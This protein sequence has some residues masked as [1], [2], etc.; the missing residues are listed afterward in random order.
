MYTASD[1]PYY[2]DHGKS[3]WLD[4]TL[5]HQARNTKLSSINRTIATSLGSDETGAGEGAIL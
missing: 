5:E 1:C 2:V 4:S 3:I